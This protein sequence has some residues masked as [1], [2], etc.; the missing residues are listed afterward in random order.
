MNDD[1]RAIKSGLSAV[2]GILLLVDA[3]I[4]RRIIRYGLPIKWIAPE[5]VGSGAN[6]PLLLTVLDW[7]ILGSLVVLQVGLGWVLWHLWKSKGSRKPYLLRR[8][9]GEEPAISR[10]ELL[11]SFQ[12]KSKLSGVLV[13]KAPGLV[14]I[15]LSID[16]LRGWAN[17]PWDWGRVGYFILFLPFHLFLWIWAARVLLQEYEIEILNGQFSFRRF[18]EW[19]SVPLG[20]IT[21]VRERIL[22]P[23]GVHVRIDYSGKCQ[24]VVFNPEDNKLGPSPPLVVQFLR[25]V[26]KRNAE[27]LDSPA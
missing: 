1:Y 21:M 9:L 27:K 13:S 25:E 7:V 3:E 16:F 26:C 18:L 8:L 4:I 14:A 12:F 20:S 6:Q 24:W 17:G 11:Q 10:E 19:R 5:G 2:A 23:P 15:W 22:W